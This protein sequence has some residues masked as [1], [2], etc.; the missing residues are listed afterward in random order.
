MLPHFEETKAVVR[1]KLSIAK[2]ILKWLIQCIQLNGICIL[3]SNQEQLESLCS[4]TFYA[5]EKKKANRCILISVLFISFKI[6]LY[7][8]I[9]CLYILAHSEKK[10]GNLV[11]CYFWKKTFIS[12]PLSDLNERWALIPLY[13]PLLWLLLLLLHD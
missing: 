7:V 10:L 5:F 8:K 4:D 2:K 6:I 11:P 3:L 9:R 1:I 13:S 12:P